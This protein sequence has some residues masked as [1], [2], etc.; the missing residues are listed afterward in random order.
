MKKTFARIIIKMMTPMAIMAFA[1]ATLAADNRVT[2]SNTGT[3]T[4]ISSNGT[5]NHAVGKFPTRGNP[6]SFRAQQVKYCFPQNPVK[7]AN[8]ST[9]ARTVG[10]SLTGIPFRPATA[11]WYDASSPRKHSRDNA[12]G[13]NLEAILPDGKKTL[14]LDDNDAHVDSRGLYHYHKSTDKY[15]AKAGESLIGYAADGHEIHYIGAGAKVSWQLKTGERPTAPFGAY[16]GQF[17]QDYEFIANSGDL[18]KCNGKEYQGKY[19]YFATD[20][21]PFFPRCHWGNIDPSFTLASPQ[22]QRQRQQKR[23]KS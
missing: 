15:L 10:I 14:G 13:W 12:S 9:Q 7:N 21:F 20:D 11:D 2:I 8:A 23:K 17:R 4:C 6:N 5:P 19:V 22:P 3:V 16:D 1:T 18:D